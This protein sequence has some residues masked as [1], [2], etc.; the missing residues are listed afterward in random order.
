MKNKKNLIIIA[1]ISLFFVCM[2]SFIAGYFV[3][4]NFFNKDND[5]INYTKIVVRSAGD[6]SAEQEIVGEI[7]VVDKK[8]V[9]ESLQQTAVDYYFLE[10]K[11]RFENDRLEYPTGGMLADGTLWDG[12]AYTDISKDDFLRGVY[13]DLYQNIDGFD[14]NL[15]ESLSE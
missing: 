12:V 6:S 14:F 8:L 11:E 9:Y 10:N 5:K 7:K 2:L 13:V 1:I 3:Y 4:Q 15:Q